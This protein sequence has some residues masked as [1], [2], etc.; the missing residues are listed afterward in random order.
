MGDDALDDW[1]LHDVTPLHLQLY[2]TIKIRILSGKDPPNTRLPSMRELANTVGVN[3]AI[4]SKAFN[5]LKRESLVNHTKLGYSVS[6]GQVFIAQIRKEEAKTKACT[7][8]WEL[9]ELG[10]MPEE[11]MA[12]VSCY[13]GKLIHRQDQ[14]N[15]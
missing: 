2:G 8:V 7:L 15:Y 13:V 1:Q 14:P 4:V 12:E 9:T 5:R 3:P 6:D 11:I 10:Y